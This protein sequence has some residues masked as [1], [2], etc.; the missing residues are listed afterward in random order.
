MKFTINS[1]VLTKVVSDLIKVIPNKTTLP[2]LTNILLELKGDLLRLTAND[3]EITMRGILKTDAAEGEAKVCIPARLLLDLL[4]TLPD[5]PVTFKRK[6]AKGIDTMVINWN[7]G[8][9]NVPLFDEKDFPETKTPGDEDPKF[10]CNTDTIN[11]AISKTIFAVGHDDTRP[12]LGSVYFDLNPGRSSIVACDQRRLACYDLETPDVKEPCSFM[13]PEKAAEIVK[14]T[15][16]K[17]TAITITFN[18]TCA[19][20]VYGN[21]EVNTRTVVGR[22]PK[23]REIIPKDNENVMETN[24][25]DLISTLKRM[26]VL[27][28][29]KSVIARVKISADGFQVNTEDTGLKMQ[30]TET[31]PITY[32]GNEINICINIPSL[33]E[34][35]SKIYSENVEIRLK[36]E[37]KAMIVLPGSEDREGEPYT[38]L[39]M[40]YF[41]K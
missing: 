24:R 14:N 38:A 36:D 31:L 4:G 40:P 15:L 6:D 13:L 21:M 9:S 22:Y 5:G 20:F 7:N 12:A 11:E 23:Y 30:G 29:R 10:E 35:L 28:E 16:P 41:I 17:D 39:V 3:M 32:R 19:R 27:A 1:K 8:S 25:E 37:R 33:V 26:S 34:V 18:N 2:I